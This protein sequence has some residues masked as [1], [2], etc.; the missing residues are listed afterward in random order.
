MR[1]T[2]F[3]L[4]ARIKPAGVATAP[5]VHVGFQSLVLWLQRAKVLRRCIDP[6][7]E[8]QLKWA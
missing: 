7:A 4:S 8:R 1:M 6:A 5:S 3:A 2:M